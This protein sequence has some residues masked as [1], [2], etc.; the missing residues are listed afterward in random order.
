VTARPC[1]SMSAACG[2]RASKRA[3]APYRSGPSKTWVKTK[4]PAS[5]AVRREREEQWR[6]SQRDCHVGLAATPVTAANALANGCGIN[7][8]ARSIAA[9][10]TWA[11]QCFQPSHAARPTGADEVLPLRGCALDVVLHFIHVLFTSVRMPGGGISLACALSSG[12]T[13]PPSRDPAF[14]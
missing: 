4:N 10:D 6:D 3:D 14:D 12:T 7:V 5:A 9:V 13:T 8:S 2:W 11:A 1:S